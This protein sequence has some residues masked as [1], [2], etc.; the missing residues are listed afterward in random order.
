MVPDLYKGYHF[1]KQMHHDVYPSISADNPNLSV[2][3][4][5]VL[6]TG[7]GSGIGF[8]SSYSRILL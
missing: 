8:V 6:I 2:K 3:G 7:G 1:T 4:Q 5:T